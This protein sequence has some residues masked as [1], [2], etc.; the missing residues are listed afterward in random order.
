V[1]DEKPKENI[2]ESEAEQMVQ[3][4]NEQETDGNLSNKENPTD[5]GTKTLEM[6]PSSMEG[7]DLGQGDPLP[8]IDPTDSESPVKTYDEETIVVRRPH[9]TVEETAAAAEA[10]A[11]VPT[12]RR[13]G[14]TH[15]MRQMFGLGA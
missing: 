12:L 13:S 4:G 10:P 6:T 9:C 5:R 1:F 3:Q 15:Q 11:S 8:P 2:L 7:E 14:R